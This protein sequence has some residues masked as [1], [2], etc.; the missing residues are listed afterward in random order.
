M[1]KPL[2]AVFSARDIKEP[3]RIFKE[4]KCID[5]VMFKYRGISANLGCIEK[6]FIEH[7]EYTHLI[8]NSDDAMP[9][10]EQIAMIIADVEKYDF[11]VI[12]GCCCYDKSHNMMHLDVTIIPAQDI[13]NDTSYWS[14][15][16][17][18]LLPKEFAHK[19][20]I[21]K[22]WYQ[23]NAVM[24]IRRDVV[25]KVHLTWTNTWYKK[26]PKQSWFRGSDK[27]F[28]YIFDQLGIPQYVDFRVWLEHNKLDK[29]QG[30]GKV[31]N[32]GE[33]KPVD[34]FEKSVKE[35]PK[36]EP[37][38]LYYTVPDDLSKV[39]EVLE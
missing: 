2:F 20:M 24:C 33:K 15:L 17:N 11:P 16:R 32:N 4:I 31:W 35:L 13:I 12:A 38:Q 3:M 34:T 18:K 7:K 25:E 14:G 39:P 22:V 23:G 30:E 27:G 5:K 1:I 28:A 29:T 19:N 10:D 36:V 9:T 8:L 37:A 26:Y 21:L 6:F